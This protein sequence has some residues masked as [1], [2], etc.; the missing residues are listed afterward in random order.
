MIHFKFKEFT[1][2]AVQLTYEMITEYALQD[3]PLPRGL[4]CG[5]ETSAGN[6]AVTRF[7][8]HITIRGAHV[9]V[10]PGDWICWGPWGLSCCSDVE[11]RRTCM[12]VDFA[13]DGWH[14]RNGLG[15]FYQG[16]RGW[17][18]APSGRAPLG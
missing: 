15:Q 16:P 9:P 4:S 13:I 6:R 11:F 8:C 12:V 14:I 1:G 17:G 18:G 5:Y 3:R 2:E 7:E 10:K